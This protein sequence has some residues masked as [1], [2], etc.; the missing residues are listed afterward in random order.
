ML[1][2]VAKWFCIALLITAFLNISLTCIDHKIRTSKEIALLAQKGYVNPVSV[3]DYSLNVAVF[4]NKNG[5]HTIVS[6][7]GLGIGDYSVTARKM[8]ACLEKDNLVVFC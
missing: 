4:G 3:G 5:A 1:K 2:K 7:S 8:T 6:L